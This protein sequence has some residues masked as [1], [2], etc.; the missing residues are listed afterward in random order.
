[1]DDTELRT[2]LDS[3]A[4]R[5]APP[6]QNP[7]DLVATVAERSR[8]GRRRQ[9]L[10]V[11][12]AAAVVAVLV[13]VPAVRSELGRD[14][15]PATPATPTGV[16]TTPT[17]G[18]LAGDTGF[19]EGLRRRPWTT[20]G[21][22]GDVPQPPLDTRHV[23]YVTRFEGAK[24][25]LVAGA[26]PGVVGDTSAAP[27]DLDELGSV[28]IAWF[29]GP[30]DAVAEEMR[31]YGEPRI[32]D[33]DEPVALLS[34]T[35]PHDARATSFVVVVG[36]PGDQ[37]EVSFM[38]FIGP[39][40]EI[41]RQY[42][43]LQTLDGIASVSATQVDASIDRALRYRVLRNGAEFT[44]LPDTEPAR[45]FVPPAIDFT[46]VRP[47]PPP[48]PGDAA[49]GVAVDELLST[50]GGWASFVD[51]TMVWAGDLPVR[52]GG[53]ARLSVVAA[54]VHGG[55]VWVGGYLGWASGS[56]SSAVACGSEIR[57]AGRPVGEQVFV[58][59]C[60]PD[61]QADVLSK[62]QLVVVGPPGTASAQL[63]DADGRSLG[64]YPLDDG[65]ALVPVPGDVATVQVRDASGEIVHDDPPMGHATLGD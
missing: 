21:S 36:A 50:L 9:G 64:S 20:R 40:G 38:R 44:G 35:V 11:A 30:E 32:V 13:A 55:G 18:M 33:S 37:V 17:R 22:R 56:A 54:E 4:S 24:W 23:V 42:E 49:V 65:V 47:A 60:A 46:R 39:D 29:T 48:A 63:L 59:L 53:T 57:P 28:E 14:T 19:V 62:S 45:D 15:D 31:V 34:P 8:A 52:D 6:A 41:T 2:R 43:P 61:G 1:M 25:A 51:F 7:D 10:L 5:T 12:A 16:Y 3:L 27:A 26:P 58:V